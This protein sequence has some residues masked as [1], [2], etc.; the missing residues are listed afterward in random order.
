MPQRVG[1]LIEELIPGVAA[2][3][4][5]WHHPGKGVTLCPISV[6]MAWDIEGLNTFRSLQS[7][8]VVGEFAAKMFGE[9]YRAAPQPQRSHTLDEIKESA[10]AIKAWRPYLNN[11]R[12]L[13]AI[14]ELENWDHVTG[15]AYCLK[16]AAMLT[17]ILP[18]DQFGSIK[19]GWFQDLEGEPYFIRAFLILLNT[20]NGVVSLR[21]DL[22]RLNLRRIKAG[23]KKLREFQITRLNLSQH[24]TRA[25][26]QKRATPAEV[27]QH[28]VRGHFKV[29]RS[30][31]FWWSPF[32]RGNSP[33]AS[34][35]E[36]Y[37]VARQP[38]PKG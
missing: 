28:Y 11:P 6:L 33:D 17:Q 35:R 12:E 5:A 34:P 16:F 22:S 25:T 26:G 32:V 4:W 19:R 13:D 3:T 2:V 1:A 21:E 29:R 10:S 38:A 15:S 31:V 27:R 8:P 24:A 14:V 36:H 37:A 30:G 23:K 9:K 18:P 20:K 7:D